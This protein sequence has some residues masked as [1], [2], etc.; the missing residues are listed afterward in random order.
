MRTIHILH[1]IRASITTERGNWRQVGGSCNL[2]PR[3]VQQAVSCIH[4]RGVN[5]YLNYM[6][7]EDYEVLLVTLQVVLAWR[8]HASLPEAAVGVTL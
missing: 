4:P 6:E 8:S 2:Y 5:I 7:Q 3:E 1:V